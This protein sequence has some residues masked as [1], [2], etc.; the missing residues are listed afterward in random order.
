MRYVWVLFCAAA[1]FGQGT[2]TKPKAEDYEVHAV[3]HGVGIGA[4]YMVHSFSRGDKMFLA[5]NYLVVEVALFPPQDEKI[6][7]QNLDFALR[8]NGKKTGLAPESVSLVATSLQHP[9]W[10]EPGPYGEATAQ[11]GGSRVSIGGLPRTQPIPGTNP[12]GSEAP[13]RIDIPRNNPGGVEPERVKADVVAVETALVEGPHQAAFSGFLY[14]PYKGKATGVKTL[15]LVY[16]DAVLK[17][18]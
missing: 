5:K 16:R 10:Q 12:P 8:V 4:E 1:A 7:V 2:E 6:T 18:K 13:P 9:E 15:E 3:A 14:F 11:G 17:L